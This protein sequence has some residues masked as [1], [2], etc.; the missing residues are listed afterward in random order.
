MGCRT[1]CVRLT[2]GFVTSTWSDPLVSSP[3]HPLLW[4]D[5]SSAH[6]ARFRK[7][8]KGKKSRK[9]L[10]CVVIR[11]LTI[12][13]PLSCPSRDLS[14]QTGQALL[15]PGWLDPLDSTHLIHHLA[16]DAAI[17]TPRFLRAQRATPIAPEGPLLGSWS[18]TK[19]GSPYIM[20]RW[21]KNEHLP[22]CKIRTPSVCEVSS[23]ACVWGAT[24]LMAGS[25]ASSAQGRAAFTRGGFP[26]VGGWQRPRKGEE[27]RV[28][29]AFRL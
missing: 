27:L 18:Q 13:F 12:P 9:S 6:R 29:G 19:I 16:P 17:P 1:N 2:C 28:P 10:W 24:P 5:I 23:E 21:S 11:Y 7:T 14:P 20:Q 4:N 26:G 8:Q 25:R 3:H 22:N 15:L